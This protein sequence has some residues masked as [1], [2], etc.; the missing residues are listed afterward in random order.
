MAMCSNDGTS[1]A[2]TAACRRW[3]PTLSL[4]RA[5]THPR[6]WYLAHAQIALF[7]ATLR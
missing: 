3:L 6:A 7:S 1:H 4:F 5:L 2:V